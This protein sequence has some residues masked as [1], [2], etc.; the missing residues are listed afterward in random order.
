MRSCD[1]GGVWFGVGYS[2][3]QDPAAVGRWLS[4]WDSA[5][6]RRFAVADARAIAWTPPGCTPHVATARRVGAGHLPDGRPVTVTWLLFTYGTTVV[7][8]TA[9]GERLPPEAAAS[10]ADGLR[11]G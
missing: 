9:Y 2:T 6:A 7:Q 8:A 4:E 3:G 10:F 5:L 11:C 1:V